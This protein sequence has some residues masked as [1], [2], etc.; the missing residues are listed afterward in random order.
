MY[1]MLRCG[2]PLPQIVDLETACFGL[3][4]KKVPTMQARIQRKHWAR[5]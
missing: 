1:E 2:V 3:V 5:K 4:A